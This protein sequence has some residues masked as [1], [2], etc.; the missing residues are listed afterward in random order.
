MSP[1]TVRPTRRATPAY[2]VFVA[3][4]PTRRV[5]DIVADKWTALVIGALARDTRRFQELKREVGGVTQKMLTQ[6]L[7]SL[8]RDGLVT[9]RAWATV[10]PRV[11]YSLTPL[12]RTL[13]EPLAAV[14]A[15]AEAHV[16]EIEAAR[17]AVDA[18]RT[19]EAAAG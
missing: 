5:L 16:E 9:R 4:C 1:T 8:E 2:D 14:R 11:E 12:G 13:T 15:W 10:P 17:K 7:R 18:R 3:T 6:T 19:R